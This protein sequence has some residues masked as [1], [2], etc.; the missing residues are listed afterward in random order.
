V[1]FSESNAQ[2]ASMR[3]SLACSSRNN[4]LVV[5]VLL[6]DGTVYEETGRLDFL[7]LSVDPATGT[8]ALRARVPNAGR[9]LLPGQFVRVRGELNDSQDGMVVPQRAVTL[10]PDG[11]TV[12]VLV[13]G[14]IAQPRPVTLG[15]LRGDG[16]V[17]LSGLTAGERIIVDGL[18][19]VR[20]GAPVRVANDS[21]SPA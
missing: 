2:L 5:R 3:Q 18:Q 15:Q 4:P 16:W 6:E 19:R 12:M 8:M 11:A 7:D 10:V 21:P 1:N 14:D 9:T 17:V 13:E 20:P